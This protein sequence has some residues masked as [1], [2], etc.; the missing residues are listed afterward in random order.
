MV[1]YMLTSMIAIDKESV[2]PIQTCALSWNFHRHS[3]LM[4]SFENSAA[5]QLKKA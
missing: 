5:I 1:S 2:S 3:K 4:N